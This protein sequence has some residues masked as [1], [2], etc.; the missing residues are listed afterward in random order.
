M[1]GPFGETLVV[2]WG[3][4]KVVGRPLGSDGASEGTLRP[5]SA[6][7]SA[8]T[9]VGAAV[10]TP[11][12]MS[13]EQAAGKID[14]LGPP[15]DVY[16]LGAT[17]YCLLAGQAPFDGRDAGE[18]LRK[19]QA[20]DFRPVRVVKR[21]V[22]AALEAVCLKAMA[23]RPVDRYRS[24][25]VLADEVEHWLAD[26]PVAAYRE[27]WLPRLARWGRRHRPLVAAA[28]ALLLTAVVALAA[29]VV[30]VNREREAAEAARQRTR[31][32]LDEMP[33]QVIEDWLS[34]QATL[35]PAQREFLQMALALYEGFAAESGQTEAI[36]RGVA[37]AHL[38]VGTIR[39]KLGQHQEAEM[40]FVRARELYTRLVAEFPAVPRYRLE[41]ARCHHNLALLLGKTSR[42]EEAERAFGD[43]LAIREPLAAE[44]PT[45]A[46]YRLELANT[47]NDLGNLLGDMGRMKEVEQAY[48][49]ALDLYQPLA[50]EFPAV[51]LYRQKLAN[52]HDNLGVLLD[53]TGRTKEAEGAYADALDLQ[54]RLAADF[55]KVPQYRQEL[56]NTHNNLGNLLT[57]MG[58]AREAEGA[59]ADALDLQNRLAADFPKVPDYRNELAGT[60]GNRA[61]LANDR[62][63]FGAARRELEEALPHHHAALQVS[64]RNPYYRQYYQ[65]N[66]VT[67]IASCV[68][69][70]DRA[71]ALQAAKT[72]RDLGWDPAGNAYNAACGLARYIS[73]IEQDSRADAGRRRQQAQFF[74]DQ[75]LA[76]L[77]TAV[78]KGYKDV[79]QLKE[80]KDLDPLRGRDEFRK[81]LTDL[82][83]A[84]RPKEGARP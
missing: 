51:R 8:P 20:G 34:R 83:A 27:R 48:R 82:E 32:A 17:L 58:R 23:L 81:L 76:M 33:S 79:A 44:Y 84:V 70:Q 30:V 22:P 74:G 18:V 10:G 72:L 80:D 19:V 65:N 2:D 59:Y 1:L 75:A 78:A 64:P 16:S 54:K 37:G 55:P 60:L 38:R 7:G 49:N 40:A 12:Y 25:R 63:D 66:L 52:I 3:L 53:N 13:S 4:A 9:L 46:Q 35:E 36:R 21:G 28:L 14:D 45:V 15:S 11:A 47:H 57:A 67:L 56:A 62:H 61:A 77:R 73:V 41:L 68:G 42:P 69:L 50:A 43:A 39:E 6:E 71:A 26:E 24:A 5:A 31:T 29:G